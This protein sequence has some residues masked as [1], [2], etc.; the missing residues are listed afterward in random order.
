MSVSVAFPPDTDTPG[1]AAEN[2]GKPPETAEISGGGGLYSAD[3]VARRMLAGIAA[4]RYVL[5]NP[6]PVLELHARLAQGLCPRALPGAALEAAAGAL[7]PLV[8]GAWCAYADRVAARGAGARAAAA[9]A[10]LGRGGGSSGATGGGAAVPR[11][12]R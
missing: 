6:D 3:A 10:A 9:A 5:A 4:G 8:Y 2:V 11:R 7:A 1:L 12:R